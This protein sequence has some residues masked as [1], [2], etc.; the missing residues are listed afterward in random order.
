[1]TQRNTADAPILAG[2]EANASAHTPRRANPLQAAALAVMI[3]VGLG[4]IYLDVPPAV[5]WTAPSRGTNPFSTDRALADLRNISRRPHP[6]G[7]PEHARVR[8][9]ILR[10]LSDSGLSPEKQRAEIV[11]RENGMA[12]SVEN[13]VARIKGATA[14]RAVLLVAH[15]DS[16]PDSFGA[17]DN[18]AAVAGLLETARMFRRGRQP[19]RDVVF[20]FT[21]GEE[22]GLLGARAFAAEN[23]LARQV[24]FVINFDARGRSGPVIL[25]ETSNQNGW[26]IRNAAEALSRPNANSASYEIYRRLPNSTD[27]TVFKQLGY[28]GANCAF[29][30]GLTYYHTPLDSLSNLD[31]RSLQQQ[32]EY[33]VE[34]AEW[35]GNASGEDPKT[36]NLVYF[37]ILGRWMVRYSAFASFLWAGAALVLLVFVL[38]QMLRR[39]ALTRKGLL[40]GAFA[41]V[42]CLAGAGVAAALAAFC[43]KAVDSGTGR[44]GAAELYH[45]GLY[46]TGIAAMGLGVSALILSALA[47]R[48]GIHSQ[49]AGALCVWFLLTVLCQGLVAGASFLF[50]WPLL[51]MLAAWAIISV[52]DGTSES[53]AIAALGIG[54]IPG[55]VIVT[56]MAHKLFTAFAS[57]SGP[58]LAV[59]LSAL[60]TLVFAPLVLSRVPRAR[61]VS[62]AFFGAAIGVIV[63]SLGISHFDNRHPAFDSAFY[64]ADADGHKQY[65]VSFDNRPDPWTARL[66][67]RTAERRSIPDIFPGSSRRYLVGPA[68][69]ASLAP[70]VLTAVGNSAVTGGRRLRIRVMSAREA[71]IVLLSI[72]KETAVRAAWVDGKA[73]PRLQSGSDYWQLEY[74]GM[75]KEGI[76]VIVETQ[77]E[78]PV[79]VQ[80]ADVSYGLPELPGSEPGGRPGDLLPARLPFDN[81]TVVTKRYQF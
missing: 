71:P 3:L 16:V 62:A 21:D 58:L 37:D 38:R 59:L 52:R 39:S 23:P 4:T 43:A 14:E 69:D 20:L 13:V 55:I 41:A 61:T 56:P 77:G 22:F 72:P 64:A 19:R 34:L 68:P 10:S 42:L 30:D 60:L 47:R 12:A 15:Y 50:V 65:W 36:G 35:F 70:P 27:F 63:V 46:V 48:F 80:A 54:A 74:L 53:I 79:R 25:F 78:A 8:D 51:G 5:Q 11:D 9:Y 81:T 6:V 49:A 7:S 28:S 2:H 40:A 31:A 18:G 44:M 75:R 33:A 26:V 24:G 45:P 29:I 73:F 57:G 67:G 32:G 66:L 17:S 1:M 76:E